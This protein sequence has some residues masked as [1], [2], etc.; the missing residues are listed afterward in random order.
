M[1]GITSS[2]APDAGSLTPPLEQPATQG[3][4]GGDGTANDDNDTFSPL[5]DLVQRFPDLFA[6]KVLAHLPP[7]DRNFVAQAGGACRAAVAASI[8]RARERGRRCWRGEVCG[9]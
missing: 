5:L 8:C 9:W 1:A 4:G 3:P 6:Q 7:I 2:G